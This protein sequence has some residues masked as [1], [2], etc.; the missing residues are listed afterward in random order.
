[1]PGQESR[2]VAFRGGG[3]CSAALVVFLPILRVVLAILVLLA[4]GARLLVLRLRLP[5]RVLHRLVRASYTVAIAAAL[6]EM[7]FR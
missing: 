1:M 4:L 2:Y 5:V 7:S 3:E 6:A